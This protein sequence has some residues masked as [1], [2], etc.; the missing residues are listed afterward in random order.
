[1]SE[2]DDTNPTDANDRADAIE[3]VLD[4]VIRRRHQGEQ[5]NDEQVI[6]ANQPLMP[7][8]AARLKQLAI[9]QNV[10][11]ASNQTETVAA[12]TGET[13]G[14][15]AGRFPQINHYEI[16]AELGSGGQA[17]VFKARY[18][19]HITRAV[20]VFREFG[21]EQSVRQTATILD[22]LHD[23][24][25]I[26]RIEDIGFTDDGKL[27]LGTEFISGRTLDAFLEDELRDP[28]VPPATVLALFHRIADIVS[29]AHTRGVIH[30]DLKPANII[31]DDRQDP[32]LLDFDLARTG[33]SKVIDGHFIGSLPWAAPE[34][35]AQ[36][37]SKVDT[38]TDVYSL[39]VILYYMLTGGRFPYAHLDNIGEILQE[40]SR[41]AVIRPSLR[42]E[43]PRHR[44]ESRALRPPE[45]PI[46]SE[47][48]WIVLKALSRRRDDR[49][50][51]A[52]ELAD[53]IKN[54]LLG[55]RST[56]D[57]AGKVGG[58]SEQ[59]GHAPLAEPAKP[60]NAP[61]SPV[62]D[63]ALAP[64]EKPNRRRRPTHGAR[65]LLVIA[66][67]TI[68]TTLAVCAI[69]YASSFY[70]LKHQYEMRTGSGG[71]SPQR[72]GIAGGS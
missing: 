71:T 51:S 39:G 17:R 50:R 31:V 6:A 45:V 5:I 28:S 54:Y 61:A 55:R 16:I 53:A 9:V 3:R 8:V 42:M 52:G 24:R 18:K 27:Y 67:I 33:A 66:S 57:Q 14:P 13:S 38:R 10:W 2:Q 72:L 49:F 59:T 30:G 60:A 7:E 34:Q 58:V 69:I 48:E 47:I 26:V 70:V 1:M 11:D 46:N 37:Q 62:S 19:G 29:F 12:F 40:I 4:D 21:D 43:Q 20:K 23:E 22:N 35:A 25:R 41:A 65:R 32:H 44:S 36:Q 68:F 15:V 63:P 56:P 64:A